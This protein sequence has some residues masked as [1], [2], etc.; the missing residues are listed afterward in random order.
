MGGLRVEQYPDVAKW[1]VQS[2]VGPPSD[3]GGAA[4][5]A[6]EAEDQPHGGG[7]TRPV[8]PEEAGDPAGPHTER[9]TVHS[10]GSAVVLGEL[11][12]FDRGHVLS[13]APRRPVLLPHRCGSSPSLGG[14]VPP[15]TLAR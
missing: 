15:G 10:A 7:L 4:G 14:A 13:L 9:E 6:V 5:G 3:R 2:R 8:R 11:V 12:D 1:I